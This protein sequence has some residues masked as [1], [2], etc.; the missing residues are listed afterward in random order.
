MASGREMNKKL[1]LAQINLKRQV[2]KRQE[3]LKDMLFVEVQDMLTDFMTSPAY[4]KL[5]EQQILAFIR[6]PEPSCR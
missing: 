4:P 1:A 5:L 3:E 2:S 6:K